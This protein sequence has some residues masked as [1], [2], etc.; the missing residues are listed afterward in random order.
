MGQQ[1]RRTRISIQAVEGRGLAVVATQNLDPGLFGLEIFEEKA[2]MVFPPMGTKDDLSGPVP[3]F[4]DPCPQLFVDWYAYLQEPKSIRTKVMKLYNDMKCPHANALRDYLHHHRKM[5]EQETTNQGSLCPSGRY[6]LDNIE[7]FI[8][9]TMVI[10]FNSVELQPADKDG[11]GPGKSHG[12]GLFETACRMNHS[13]KPN[14]VWFT[15]QDGKSKIVR[16]VSAI[17]K[18]EEL[19]IDYSGNPLEATPARRDEILQTK[20]FLC[21]C[22]RCAAGH[23]DTRRFACVKCGGSHFLHQPTYETQPRLLP[24][25]TCGATASKDYLQKVLKEEMALVHEINAI[26]AVADEEGLEAVKNRICNLCPPHKY[27]GLAEKCYQLQ[28]ELQSVMGNYTKS[29]E[30]YA[31]AI[32][33][34]ISILGRE[35]MSTATAF[36]C[37]KMGD[38]LLKVNVVEAEEAYRRTVRTLEVMRGRVDPYSQC[39][40]EK[41][42]AVQTS[43]CNTNK[44]DLPL[45]E[46]L[47]GIAGGPTNTDFPCKLCGKP[48]LVAS[49]KESRNYCCVFHKQIHKHTVVA[50]E[51]LPMFW[52]SRVPA[53]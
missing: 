33:C 40:M 27:H 38:A 12:H 22:E 17:S 11:L 26:N 51:V 36:T 49:F 15:T 13:C 21:N 32:D 52:W 24:C 2:L 5:A 28:G 31:K 14:C 41:L 8:Q 6:I 47:T 18:G 20:G 4:L 46:C 48:S 34:R 43:R 19:T 45:E 3:N 37:E 1:P 50:E 42:L 29:A 23:D 7:E 39:A 10:R 25:T 53:M 9:F 44:C 16:A 30:A 35:T